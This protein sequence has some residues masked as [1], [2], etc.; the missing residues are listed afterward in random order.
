LRVL[1]VEDSPADARLILELLRRPGPSTFAL[2]HEERLD[3]ALAAVA[4]ETFDAVL[5]DLGLPDSFGLETLARLVE[6]APTLPIVVSTGRVEEG[7]AIEA[8][9]L[10][11]QEYVLKDSWTGEMLART[12]RYAVERKHAERK[13]HESQQRKTAILDAA[14]D[15]IL[16]IDHQGRILEFNPAAEQIFGYARDEVIGRDMAE[17][18]IPPLYRQAH[19]EG[20]AQLIATGQGRLIGRRIELSALRA[21]GTEFPVELSITAMTWADRPLFTGFVRDISSRVEAQASL[22]QSEEQYRQLFE[23]H[24]VPMWVY[25]RDTLFFLAANDA[26]VQ[27]Y[28]WSRAEFLAMQ[29]PDLL[30]AEERPHLLQAL[31][32]ARGDWAVLGLGAGGVW[33]HLK[34]DGA[35]IEVEG[36]SSVIRFEGRDARLVLAADV[37][38]RRRLAA[39]LIEAQK[40]EAVAQLAGG[41]AHDFNN[42]LTV[43]LGHGD[44]LQATLAP[45]AAAALSCDQIRQAAKRA[46]NLTR[47]LLTFSRKQVVNPQLVDLNEEIRLIEELLRPLVGETIE[48]VTLLASDA[49]RVLADHGQLEQI[50]LN[51][52]INAKDAMPKGGRLLFETSN[53]EVDAALAQDHPGLTPGLYVRLCVSDNGSGIEPET[54]SHIFEPFF[55]TK[56]IG[57]GTGLGLSTVHGI[58]TQSGGHVA[59]YSE[60]GH[61]TTFQ[62]FLPRAEVSLPEARASQREA[63]LGGP[64]TVLVVEDVEQLRKLV[65]IFLRSAGYEVIEATDPAHAM[66]ISRHHPQAIHCLLTDVVMPRQSGPELAAHLRSER[67]ELRTLF[68]SGYAPEAILQ[69]GV[70]DAQKHF[71]Q[72]PFSRNA[73]LR[74]LRDVLDEPLEAA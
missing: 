31:A 3:S 12:L 65:G 41:I 4:R 42:L 40:M 38:E 11:A 1:L 5:L 48:L 2:R 37:T 28:G 35:R 29:V 46:A 54:M 25:D 34:K 7:L 56:P 74:K 33:T 69:H 18:I 23:D 17:L 30:A 50:L 67:G 70:I 55:T 6:A 26:A 47:Q 44:L 8:L 39:R 58:V 64:E 66:E 63:P 32:A 71:L 45:G 16:T 49:G 43:I 24:P 57:K 22:R 27:A 59:V 10:G 68:L 14:L 72:K 36:A 53:V 21:D 62:I 52:A 51:L 20:M 13:L 73:L 15:A 19:R 60:I 9:R 61:G